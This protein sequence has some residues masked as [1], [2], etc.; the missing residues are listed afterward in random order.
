MMKKIIKFLKPGGKICINTYTHE[1]IR[2]VW[3]YDLHPKAMEKHR[4]RYCPLET[5]KE[6]FKEAG[7]ENFTK[8]KG[9]EPNNGVKYYN[10]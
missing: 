2:G 1:N 8:I 9:D 7:F 4:A 10:A 3:Y 5:C 6:I